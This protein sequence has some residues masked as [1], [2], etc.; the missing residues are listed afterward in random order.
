M[1]SF[2]IALGMVFLAEMGDKTQLV[3]LSLAGRYKARLTIAGILAA[4]AAV[5]V[6]SVVIG[7]VLGHNLSSSW[8][9]FLAGICF[10]IFGIWTLRG[11]DDEAGEHRGIS[12]FWI[13]FWT[14]LI[15]EMGDKT[16][17][18]TA[19]VAAQHS[20]S[21]L[22][23]WLGSTIGMVIADALA[24]GL[25]VVVGMRLPELLIRRIAGGIFLVFGIWS[26]WMGG[27][28]LPWQAWVGGAALLAGGLLILFRDSFSKVAKR[29]LSAH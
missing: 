25:G 21:W 2:L 20:R 11:D 27:R 9:T 14:F 13:I 17:F 23:V 7:A 18:T 24:I 16:M 29:D 26:S 19:T 15:A 5:H 22:P 28:E 8:T 12:P 4:T 10:L 6:L 1:D 3:A